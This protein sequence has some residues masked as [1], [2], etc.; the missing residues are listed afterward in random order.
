MKPLASMWISV[1]CLWLVTVMTFPGCT[2][3]KENDAFSRALVQNGVVRFVEAESTPLAKS[4]RANK[5]RIAVTDLRSVV[6]GETTNLAG[7]KSLVAQSLKGSNLTPPDMQLVTSLIDVVAA[8]LQKR[9]GDGDITADKVYA[10]ESVLTWVIDATAFYPV[11]TVGVNDNGYQTNGSRACRSGRDTY[12][13]AVL[14][15]RADRQGIFD[16]RA[17]WSRNAAS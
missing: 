1:T 16:N 10:V 9:I 15:G 8:E 12:R 7:L 14:Y 2:F 13:V 3:F 17:Q 6:K 5:V 4:T 11:P